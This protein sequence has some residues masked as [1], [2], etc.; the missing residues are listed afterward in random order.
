[1]KRLAIAFLR[2]SLRIS[3]AFGLYFTPLR[4]SDTFGFYFAAI[5]MDLKTMEANVWNRCG[6]GAE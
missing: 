1:M 5:L 3:D 4:V 2:G 6:I